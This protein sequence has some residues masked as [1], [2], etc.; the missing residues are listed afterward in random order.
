MVWKNLLILKRIQGERINSEDDSYIFE[1]VSFHT[2]TCPLD[3]N[4]F[5]TLSNFFDLPA[6]VVPPFLSFSNNPEPHVSRA[7]SNPEREREKENVEKASGFIEGG[8]AGR[9]RRVC[10]QGRPN[11]LKIQTHPGMHPG[12]GQTAGRLLRF[13]REMAGHS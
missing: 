9:T 4:T 1:G 3:A 10:G 6:S 8:V 12:V 7:C 13:W 5:A 11:G 2:T